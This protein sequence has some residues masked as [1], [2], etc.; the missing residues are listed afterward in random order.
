[1]RQII[2]VIGIF[3]C[4]FITKIKA[5]VN[6]VLNPSFEQY[7][8][9]P[10]LLDQIKYA[11]DWT[12]IDSIGN[13]DS[14]FYQPLCTPDYCNICDTTHLSMPDLA[15]T[16]PNDYYFYHYPRTGNGMVQV[17]MLID[18]SGPTGLP[19]VRDYLQ[20]RL[21][22]P[23]TADKNYCVTFYT[24]LEQISSYAIDKIGA[25][26]DDGS[27]DIGQDSAGCANPQTAYTP[28]IYA[29]A[30]ISDTL[31]WVQVQGLFTASGTETFI[32]IGNFFN[33]AHTDKVAFGVTGSGISV[34][35]IDDVS[36]IEIGAKPD[37]GLDA[38]VS[39]GSD[40]ATIG[41]SEEGLP[42]T[43]F[44]LGSAVPI[45]HTGSLKV[46]PDTTTTY[47]LSLDICDGGTTDTVTVWVAPAGVD[48]MQM[49]FANVQ[50]F[51][52]PTNGNFSIEHAKGLLLTIFDV[53]GKEVF[54]ASIISDKQQININD[55]P[56]GVYSAQIT[57]TK[58]GARVVR[59]IVK[60]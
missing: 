25:Y 56:G 46:H 54:T 43:W 58:T 55:L 52:N 47:V 21:Y 35:L 24:T 15:V 10:Y 42:L 27:I 18:P 11:T 57:D 12:P 37:A 36:V 20:G 30:I 19:D 44:V 41:S 29:S 28:Q 38:Y 26:L 8:K 31:N 60:D 1:V 4:A 3:T 23:L 50:I 34:Y 49:Q 59:K 45:G 14:P 2:F 40:S 16:V 32:T 48:N 51:P 13:P 5:Q 17:R 22:K 9:C 7:S 33:F 6:Y 53:L 39:P